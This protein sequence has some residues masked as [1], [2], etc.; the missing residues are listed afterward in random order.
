M[1]RLRRHPATTGCL[2]FHPLGTFDGGTAITECGF[3]SDE[4]R[5]I[6]YIDIF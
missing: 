2:E 6:M 5:C 4:K 3:G 1:L